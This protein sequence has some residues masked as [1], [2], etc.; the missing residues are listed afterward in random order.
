MQ[1]V[2][3]L[4]RNFF[5]EQKKDGGTQGSKTAQTKI[6]QS[7]VK[8]A[9]LF[10]HP[11]PDIFQTINGTNQQV[12][13][14]Q[15]CKPKLLE[16]VSISNCTVSY[17]LSTPV[18]PLR[19]PVISTQKTTAISNTEYYKQHGLISACSRHVPHHTVASR[20]RYIEINVTG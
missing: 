16:R 15:S 12:H 13:E 3:I 19:H 5:Y 14:P 10:H 1:K 7:R 20:R 18:F 17:S 8:P 2:R 9:N 6:R 4:C 11:P